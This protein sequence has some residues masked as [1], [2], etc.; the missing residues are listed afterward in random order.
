MALSISGCLQN[1]GG[2]F[3]FRRSVPQDLR[4]KIN[5]SEIIVSLCTRERQEARRRSILCIN[6]TNRLFREMRMS[7]VKTLDPDFKA[8]VRKALK[9]FEHE[10]TQSNESLAFATGTAATPETLTA[11]LQ[12]LDTYLANTPPSQVLEEGGDIAGFLQSMRSLPEL[13][14]IGSSD[15]KA[16]QAFI[17]REFLKRFRA[18]V[19]NTLRLH[20]D[21]SYE[22]ADDLPTSALSAGALPPIVTQPRDTTTILEAWEQY[23]KENSAK[24]SA[25]TAPQYESRIREFAHPDFVGNKAVADISRSDLVKYKNIVHHLPAHWKKSKQYRDLTVSELIALDISE[26]DKLSDR[27]INE[28]FTTLKAFFKWCRYGQGLQI[29]PEAV[30]YDISIKDPESSERASFTDEE[31]QTIFSLDHY[32]SKKIN[33]LYKFWVP[34]IGALSGARLGEVTQLR[35]EDIISVQGVPTIRLIETA[36]DNTGRRKLKTKAAT[37]LVPIH[38]DLITIGFIEYVEALKG[39]GYLES[40]RFS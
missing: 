38:K 15:P 32:S 4:L 31:L 10:S 5:Q 40:P 27:S 34:L 8:R 30:M 20:T 14:D 3:Y 19:E 12:G 39:R 24:W 17:Q 22:P 16:A 13:Q 11:L 7:G 29:D 35:L 1:R 25:T 23:A 9:Q 33:L 18:T 6:V 37:R 2:V 36:D 26:K 28:R 21:P